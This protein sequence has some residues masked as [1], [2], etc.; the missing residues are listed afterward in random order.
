MALKP[1]PTVKGPVNRSGYWK[2][3]PIA[4]KN[5]HKTRKR[6]VFGHGS[7]NCTDCH[8]PCKSHRNPKIVGTSSRE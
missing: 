6:W 2:L 7:K 5:G 8:V 3:W 4:Y 1:T